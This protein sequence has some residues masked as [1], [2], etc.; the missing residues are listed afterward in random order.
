MKNHETSAVSRED[1]AAAER[2][3]EAIIFA[4]PIPVPEE[5]LQSRID[6][7]LG[8]VF[9][10]LS[11]FYCAPRA[12]HLVRV[13]GGWTFSCAEAL[14]ELPPKEPEPEDLPKVAMGVMA[15]ILWHQ[16][17]T[18][19]SIKDFM[20]RRPK[21]AVMDLL[22][23][24]GWIKQGERSQEP[25][26]P[27]TWVTTAEFLAHIGIERLSDLPDPDLLQGISSAPEER[28]E[29]FSPAAMPVAGRR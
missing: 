24:Q 25:G 29:V 12:P 1:L 9:E 15:C 2:V 8:P 10:R 13:V 7:P 26:R 3:V 6:V 4:S 5:Y 17:V 22:V 11:E 14:A 18:L 19:G 21:K 23:G 16:P 27:M 28:E 20:G